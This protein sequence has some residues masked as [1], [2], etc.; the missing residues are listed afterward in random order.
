MKSKYSQKR[1]DEVA[2]KA[3]FLGY[4]FIDLS[5]RYDYRDRK[6]RTFGLVDRRTGIL[7]C[8]YSVLADIEKYLAE[9]QKDARF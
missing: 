5:D 8:A 1:I 3:S 9:N 6:Y 2:E 7:A 4:Q